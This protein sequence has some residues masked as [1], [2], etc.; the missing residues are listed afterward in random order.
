MGKTMI[1]TKFPGVHYRESK[2]RLNGRKPDVCYY[3]NYRKHGQIKWKRMGW[4]SEGFTAKLA[5]QERGH[6]KRC[7]AQGLPLPD[8]QIKI[9]TFAVA[10]KEY[11]AWAKL[12]KKDFRN[13]ESRYRNHLKTALGKKKLDEISTFTL[14]KVKAD[15][16]KKD[17]SPA[18][19]KHIL[20]I[21]REVYNKT[22]EWGQFTGTNPIR[23]G[24]LKK[25]KTNK[26]ERYL[27]YQEAGKLLA[28]LKTVSRLTHDIAIISLGTGMRFGEIAGL[29]G[30]DLDFAN[31]IISITDPKNT[32]PRKAYMNEAVN[33]TLRLRVPEDPEELIFKDRWH[34]EK[35]N[36]VSRTFD[37][38]VEKLEFNKGIVDK[39]QRVVFHTL[40][41][42]YASWLAQDDTPLLT[43]AAL[44]GHKTLA[45]SQRYAHLSPSQERDANL[46]VAGHFT[47]AMAKQTEA[48]Q[49]VA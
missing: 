21:V 3:F 12:N 48:G 9:P 13:D 30:K 11:L 1:R 6:F 5:A 40:R 27:T 22:I 41:H 26:R 42:T 4:E 46:R 34:G 20:V 49:Q 25:L 24:F 38:T 8:E 45:M 16:V 44:M 36:E 14:E 19:V 33:E 32:E 39:R 17:L 31:G 10:F 37:R 35:I 28:E 7:I 2:E 47:Q 15:L 29:R 43:I 23:R 18:T